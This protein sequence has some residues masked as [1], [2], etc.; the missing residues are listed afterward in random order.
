MIWKEF[1]GPLKGMRSRLALNPDALPRTMKDVPAYLPPSGRCHAPI[2][3]SEKPSPL[4]SPAEDTDQPLK[5]PPAALLIWNPFVPSR[6]DRLR[7]AP[8]PDALPNTT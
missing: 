8:N 2:M 7:F 1:A 4:K 3:R 5:S 6:V